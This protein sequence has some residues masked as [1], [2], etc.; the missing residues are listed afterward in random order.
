MWGACSTVSAAVDPLLNIPLNLGLLSH[1]CWCVVGADAGGSRIA[2]GCA[3]AATD[4]GSGDPECWH[5]LHC[6]QVSTV[7]GAGAAL[8]AG[9]VHGYAQAA[10][11]LALMLYRW[12]VGSLAALVACSLWSKCR[13]WFACLYHRPDMHAPYAHGVCVRPYRLCSMFKKLFLMTIDAILLTLR[14]CVE[15]VSA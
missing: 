9:K 13:P 4:G 2:A 11:C 1:V 3:E 5:H 10:M 15:D 12:R 7:C 14:R 6:Q 8:L